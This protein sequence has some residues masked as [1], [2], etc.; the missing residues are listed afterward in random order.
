MNRM[1]YLCCAMG[2]ALLAVGVTYFSSNPPEKGVTGGIPIMIAG[3][4][5]APGDG[6]EALRTAF[7]V[8]LENAK[9]PRVDDLDDCALAVSAE[10]SRERTGDNDRVSIIW[11]LH[12]A[13]G[14]SLGEVALINEVP[15]GKLDLTWGTD[16]SL[17]ARGARDGIVNIIRRQKP[18]CT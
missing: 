15:S 16:A 12:D 2:G 3:I 11:Q 17:A 9:I 13:K 18:T 6:N 8:M 10:I 14:H 5:G 4:Q 7:G 1:F